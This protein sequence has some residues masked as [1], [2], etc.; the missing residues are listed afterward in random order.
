M[1]SDEK[2]LQEIQRICMKPK[3]ERSESEIEK[4]SEF[5]EK[6][7]FLGGHGTRKT[8]TQVLL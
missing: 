7:S 6:I 8:S 4:T 2:E 1:S 5:L 3:E